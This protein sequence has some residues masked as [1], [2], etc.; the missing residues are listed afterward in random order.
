M[1][2]MKQ[3]TNYK[4][5]FSDMKETFISYIIMMIIILAITFLIGMLI[6]GCIVNLII[7]I[8]FLLY[9]K[10]EISLYFKVKSDINNN[11]YKEKIV[12]FDKIETDLKYGRPKRRGFFKRYTTPRFS[13]Y[14]EKE[15][16]R[17][18]MNLDGV[19]YSDIRGKEFKIIYL[20]KTRLIVA[21]KPNFNLK[22]S[23]KESYQSAFK[24][25]NYDI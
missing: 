12:V 1:N 24:N 18:G 3:K 14:H 21:I 15:Y 8:Y 7:L 23:M 9:F 19:V 4:V 20:E 25:I 16:Y 2:N 6:I 5:Y 17:I 13:F 10:R 22:D 11:N